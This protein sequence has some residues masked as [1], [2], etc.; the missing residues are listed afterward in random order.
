LGQLSELARRAVSA[1]AKLEQAAAA[2]LGQSF[3][4][5][6]CKGC[7]LADR[8]RLDFER[9][10]YLGPIY[11]AVQD[12]AGLDLVIMKGAQAGASTMSMLVTLWLALRTRSQLAYFLPTADL[13]HNFS[14]IRFLKMVRD[15]PMIHAAMGDP[16]SPRAR[17]VTNEGSAS[18]RRLL[19]S[20]IYFT[21]VGGLVT[22][23][24]MPLDGLVFDEVQGMS[25][26]D[27]ERAEERMS[28]SP[29][30]AV[31]RVSTPTFPA[32]DIHHFYLGSDQREF[33]TRCRC[34]DGVVLADQWD[35][36]TGPLCI[37]RGNGSTPGVPRTPFWVCPRCKT[38]INNPQDGAYRA[39]NPRA[40][41]VGFHFPQLLSPRWNAAKFLAKW[42]QHISTQTFFSRVL[43]KP[44][45]DPTTMPITLEHLEAAQD[46][47][48]RWGP[49]ERNTT[50]AMYMGIDQMGGENY[51]VIKGRKGNRMILLHLEIIQ[52]ADP[53]RR[54]AE[55]MWRYDI[56]VAVVEAL[57]NFN[58]A[59]RFAREHDGRVFVA[60]YQEHQDELVLWGDRVRDSQA[61]RYS[62]D[63]IRSPWTASVDQFKMMSW[64][65]ARLKNGEVHTPDARALTQSY[66]SDR[67]TQVV[68]ICR[69]VFWPHLL[70]VALVTEPREGHED[71]RRYRTAVKK[72][73]SDPHFA[74]AN[75]LCD[76]AWVREGRRVEIWLP[77]DVDSQPERPRDPYREQITAAFP[78]CFIGHNRDLC[79]RTC[80]N[81]VA[82]QRLC[83]H[84]D[85][86]VEPQ[87]PMCDA[88]IPREEPRSRG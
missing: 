71:E 46:P 64:S 10:R 51:V 18:T 76:V 7:F 55:L 13:A 65:L 22:T 48:L 3:F 23:E 29:L 63:E 40:S 11:E 25:L 35:P 26:L 73:G 15:N 67:G 9:W 50:D 74:Y 5:W 1:T 86:L 4:E 66:R 37:D 31:L 24:A 16:D 53:W 14:T 57:P 84:R 8:E 58:E 20:V 87:Q 39:H 28:A 85:L 82:E 54:C 27:I 6:A 44:W 30:R 36:A 34:T 72:V 80:V 81:Y 56:A 88:Y 45:A 49:P 78:E 61:V 12:P 68:A 47:E 33:H 69:D 38:V 32:S 43:G 62:A 21:Y 19:Q 70:G 41:R 52:S 77:N 59:H 2:A 75:M 79:C 83:R 42:E 17:R 60:T